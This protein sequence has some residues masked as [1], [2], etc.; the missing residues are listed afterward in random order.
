MKKI[1]ISSDVKIPF[2]MVV[3]S[4]FIMFTVQGRER[5]FNI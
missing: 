4:A 1:S 5:G 2:L 3:I